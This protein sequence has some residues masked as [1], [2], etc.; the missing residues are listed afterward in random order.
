MSQA[1]FEFDASDFRTQMLSVPDELELTSDELQEIA[2]MAV[3]LIQR[4]T[5]RGL[6]Y[7][8]QA[9][10]PYSPTYLKYRT[11]AG[12]R[13]KTGAQRHA[14]G[15]AIRDSAGRY[16]R[17]S[18]H[19]DRVTLLFT[20]KM[21]AALEGT[22]DEWGA[23]LFFSSAEA[24]T[25]ANYHNSMEP[26]KVMPLRR[27]LDF[28]PGSDVHERLAKRAAKMIADRLNRGRRR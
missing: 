14:K 20:G 12:R 8:D 10:I 25:I 26:R 2:D 13:G 24:G 23:L 28:A 27:F 6:D 4:R 18:L 16:A 3:M 9:F 19:P 21:M 7:R 15:L 11:E 17:V 1:F 22:D 5:E